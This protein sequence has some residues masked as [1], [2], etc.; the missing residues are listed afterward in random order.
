MK[1]YS[2]IATFF[3]CCICKYTLVEIMPEL[4][5]NILNY[6]YR[7]N[8]KYEGMLAHSFDSFYVVMKF[9]L[10]TMKDLKFSP[11]EFDSTCNY[12]NVDVNKK[13]FLTQFTPNFKNY[14]RKIIP[15]VDFYKKQIGSYNPTVHEI[16][17]KEI[18]LILPSFPKD[19]KDKRSIIVSLVTSF[20]GLAY[21][22]ISSYLHNKQQKALHKA[23]MAMENKVNL[24]CKKIF[25]LED[26]MVMYSIYS[27]DTLEN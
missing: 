18:S 11:I 14:C 22:C 2:L 16:L 19:R 26:S 20:I 17:T 13:H 25:H 27:L 7:I 23:C 12:L 1:A 21:D 8:F 5:R 9:I 6:G 24:Q 10:P 3:M 4:K 15:F